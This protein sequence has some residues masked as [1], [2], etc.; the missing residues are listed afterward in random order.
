[1]PYPDLVSLRWLNVSKKVPKPVHRVFTKTAHT[2][3]SLNVKL[4]KGQ[5]ISR[6]QLHRQ[7]YFPISVRNS[8]REYGEM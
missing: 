7:P 8:S 6:L 5:A 2:K 1:M 3:I 4:R